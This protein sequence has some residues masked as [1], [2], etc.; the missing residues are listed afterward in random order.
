M[1]TRALIRT[2]GSVYSKSTSIS[3]DGRW[4]AFD[5][6]L[7]TASQIYVRDTA[8][9]TTESISVQ[10]GT[11]NP[12]DR[13]SSNPLIS[14]DGRYVIFASDAANLVAG[15]ANN[16]KD[17]FI[18]DRLRGVTLLASINRAGTGSGNGNS[19]LPVLAADGRTLLFQSFASDLIPD[20]FN[21]TADVFVLRLGG[22]DSDGDGMD[23]DWEAAYFSTLARDGSGDFDGDGSTD[24]AEHQLGTDPT[25]AGS[26]FQVLKLTR[27]GGLTA[28]LLWTSMPGRTYRVQ[29]KDDLSVS[30]WSEASQTVTAAGTIAV[31]T[32][33]GQSPENRFYRVLLVP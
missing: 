10:T 25:N 15:D 21:E 29:F 1:Q 6:R 14:H 3:A 33:Q 24:A 7:L 19:L 31:W 26:V 12:A 30:G 18:R 11:T 2:P 16:A 23:D 8:L 22:T 28:K 5:G 27:D 17:I 13:S 32:E 4:I 20:D 9:Q